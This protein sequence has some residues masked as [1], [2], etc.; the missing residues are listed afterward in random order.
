MGTWGASPFENDNASDWIWEL[1]EAK[2]TSVL[3]DALEAVTSEEEEEVFEGWEEALA[4]AEVVA[5]LRGK[6]LAE[7]PEEVN[8]FV[9]EQGA[10]PPSPKLVKLAITAVERAGKAS[11]LK[12]RWEESGD[13]KEWHDTLKDLLKRLSK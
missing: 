5:A 1:A 11:D 3:S 4:A 13:A 10:K 9:K 2:D 8:V 12:E 6:P 7:L